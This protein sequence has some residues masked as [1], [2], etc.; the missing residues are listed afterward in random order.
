M[1][2]QTYVSDKVLCKLCTCEGVKGTLLCNEHLEGY[3]Y[4]CRLL[5]QTGH[6]ALAGLLEI[7]IKREPCKVEPTTLCNN[8]FGSPACGVSLT[9]LLADATC[10][11]TEAACK[12][13][14]NF[15]NF[16]RGPVYAMLAKRKDL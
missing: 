15:H 5:H 1:S 9:A 13:Y 12:S 11:K 6:K 14:D 10:S 16:N 2:D 7:A 4:A 8:V 3:T